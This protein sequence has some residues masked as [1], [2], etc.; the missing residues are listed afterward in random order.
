MYRKQLR[1]RLYSQKI[2]YV[3]KF[4]A[5]SDRQITAW[6]V[7]SL[8]HGQGSFGMIAIELYKFLKAEVLGKSDFFRLRNQESWIYE[9]KIDFLFKHIVCFCFLQIFCKCLLF[10]AK[11]ITISICTIVH[12]FGFCNIVISSVTRKWWVIAPPL[13]CRPKCR[14]KKNTAFL[15]LLRPLN[16]QDWTK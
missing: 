16:A 11:I 4:T 6:V 10:P 15:A 8:P 3:W 14:M 12:A 2:I 7:S 1:V 5:L 9:Q 13:A